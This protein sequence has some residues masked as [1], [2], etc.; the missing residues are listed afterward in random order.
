MNL[1]EDSGFDI[2][3]VNGTDGVIATN[4][5]LSST[6]TVSQSQRITAAA[7]DLLGTGGAYNLTNSG[8]NV[9]VVAANTGSLNLNNGTHDL[10]VGLINGTTGVTT[11]GSTLLKTSGALT[12]NNSVTAGGGGNALTL[13]DGTLVNNAGANALNTGTGGRW[14]IYSTNPA[15]DT[16]GGIADDFRRFS[17][18]YNGSCPAFPTSGNGLLYSYT[19]ML[20]A[21]SST[22]AIPAAQSL[23]I[24]IPDTVLHAFENPWP[25]KTTTNFWLLNNGESISYGFYE[26]GEEILDLSSDSSYQSRTRI[27]TVERGKEYYGQFLIDAELA[28]KLAST[29]HIQ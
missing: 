24:V 20:T 12:L 14:L 19:P 1:R 27:K 9:G 21:T 4:L 5:Y 16:L 10:A 18:S 23:D 3:T 11:S 15:G 8:N 25:G 2:G 6:G 26:S 29:R 28:R 13:V 22:E 17:C 7:L